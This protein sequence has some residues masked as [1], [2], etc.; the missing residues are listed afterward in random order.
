[1]FTLDPHLSKKLSFSQNG[2]VF[3]FN[4]SSGFTCWTFN[5]KTLTIKSYHVSICEKFDRDSYL[6]NSFWDIILVQKYI[7]LSLVQKWFFIKV[8]SIGRSI[9]SRVGFEKFQHF[10]SAVSDRPIKHS[11]EHINI[12][13]FKK[14][15]TDYRSIC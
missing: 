14:K 10:L 3:D 2:P 5:F 1:M 9:E 12:I 6:G 11:G 7:F 4:Q 15:R 13:L 8:C